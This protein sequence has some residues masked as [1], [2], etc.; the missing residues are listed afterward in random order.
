MSLRR[1]NLFLTIHALNLLQEHLVLQLW[2]GLEELGGVG[3]TCDNV[4]HGFR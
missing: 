3:S 4:L 2:V 1:L